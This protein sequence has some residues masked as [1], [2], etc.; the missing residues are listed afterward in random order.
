VSKYL[1]KPVVVEA[2]QW[3]KHGDHPAVYRCGIET[4]IICE[5]PFT[6]GEPTKWEYTLEVKIDGRTKY[7][8]VS[9]GDWI[10]EYKGIFSL[11]GPEEFAEKFE[12]IP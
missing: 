8:Q 10:V 5:E 12:L 7:P 9:P 3:F 4:P 11:Y 2:T 1:Y 6:L